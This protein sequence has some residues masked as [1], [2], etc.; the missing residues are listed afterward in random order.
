M[1][2]KILISLTCL[3]SL[4][5]VAN[6]SAQ[7]AANYNSAEEINHDLTLLL[8][9]KNI[10]DVTKQLDNETS[11]TVASLFRRLVIY[12]RAGH[13]SQVRTTLEQLAATPNW[14]C[15][16]RNDLV[17]LIRNASE[18]SFVTQRFYYERLCPDTVEGAEV[19]VRLWSNVGDLKELDTWLSE[20]SDRNDQ[21]LMLRVQVRARSGTAGELLDAL[22]AEIR[23][24]RLTGQWQTAEKFLFAHLDSFWRVLPHTLAEIA[25]AAAQANA[26][27]DAMR[28]WR[29]SSTS[30]DEISIPWPN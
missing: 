4:M 20:R 17:W 30:I 15:P 7:Q 19:F 11:P 6:A 2:N 3:A 5:V 18:Q 1:R 25:I 21:W 14:Q 8:L 24:I 16:A 28:L 23:A 29:M 22:A 10:N 13:A 26:I 9:D 27:D 12:S